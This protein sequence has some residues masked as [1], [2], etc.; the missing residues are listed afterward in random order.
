VNRSLARVASA[1]HNEIGRAFARPEIL[2]AVKVCYERPRQFVEDYLEQNLKLEPAVE[3]PYGGDG[4][5]SK[6][7]EQQVLNGDDKKDLN[8][9][10]G[11]QTESEDGEADEARD[12][13][14]DSDEEPGESLIMRRWRSTPAKTKLMQRFAEQCGFSAGVDDRFRHSDGRWIGKSRGSAFPWTMYSPSGDELR[15]YW[16]QNHCIESKPLEMESDVWDYVSSH[17]ESCSLILLSADR[18]PVQITGEQLLTMTEDDE[19]KLYPAAY[20]LVYKHET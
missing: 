5:S 17:P 12:N 4:P 9:G 7:K 1:V 14:E 11:G 6:Q 10:E 15:S 18:R 16:P 8:N 2:D 19:L 3:S 13:N 20:R